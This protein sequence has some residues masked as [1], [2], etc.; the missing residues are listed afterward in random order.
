[1]ARIKGID[2]PGKKRI[3]IALTAI[4]GVGRSASTSILAKLK[5]DEN[6]KAKDLND[7]Q[8][9]KIREELENYQVEGECRR[10]VSLN[11]KRL[12]E[13]ASYRGLRH[14]RGLPVRGQKT[15]SNARTWKNKRGTKKIV[16]NK[17][18][19]S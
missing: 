6:I 16:A 19:V 8:I 1:M 15:R 9:K 17:K 13:I 11:I 2:L 12:I 18:K 4:Y 10:E 3:V 14:R 7:E 5:I